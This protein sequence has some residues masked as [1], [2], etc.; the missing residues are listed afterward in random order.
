[1]S[2]EALFHVSGYVNKQQYRFLASNNL[3]ELHPCPRHSAKVTVRY[4]VS[5]GGIIGPYFS[6]DKKGQT[7]TV[8]GE[9]HTATLE[10]FL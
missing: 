1:M 3:H 10:T 2:D 7:I 6:E 9:W 8:N 5:S 4:A